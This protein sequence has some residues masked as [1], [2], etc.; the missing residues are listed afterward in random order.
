MSTRAT[1]DVSRLPVYVS[2][3][4]APLWWG[5]LFLVVIEIMV[6]GTFLTSY[7][8]YRSLAPQWPPA[9]ITPPDLFW[10]TLNTF[11]LIGSSLAIW[12]A[13]KGIRK[14]DVARLKI[15]AG[16]AIAFSAL[17]LVLKVVEY[18][19]VG[20]FWDTNAYG[21]IIWT[22]IIFHSAH[23][24]SVLLKGIVVEILAFR[25]YFDAERHLGVDVNGLYWHFVVGIWI[26]I[27]LVLYI[28]PR[29]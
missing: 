5:I 19:K 22:V 11:V 26:P 20:Y 23:V 2:G 29:L 7:F 4:R 9:G 15:G 3:A 13:D 28:V 12:W 14:G 16:A 17:F 8:Y 10:P 27:Y 25:G 24:A 21:S 6:F 18:A 1:L